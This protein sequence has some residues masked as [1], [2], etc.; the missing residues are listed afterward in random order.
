MAKKGNTKQV[1]MEA[2]LVLFS[3][4]GYEATSS[5]QM[6]RHR[7]SENSTDLFMH[8]YAYEFLQQCTL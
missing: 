1:I 5:S 4:Q 2:A 8:H 6:L 7:S 3:V